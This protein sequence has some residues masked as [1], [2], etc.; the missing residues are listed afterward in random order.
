MESNNKRT[1]SDENADVSSK[2]QKSDGLCPF[3]LIFHLSVIDT[4]STSCYCVPK[5]E[6]TKEDIE[7]VGTTD[8]IYLD[9]TSGDQVPIDDLLDTK[10]KKFKQYCTSTK[11]FLK[12]SQVAERVIFICR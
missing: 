1:A 4:D 5:S 7:K 12:E 2:Q 6:V 9:P 8:W 3:W 10:W 11:Q